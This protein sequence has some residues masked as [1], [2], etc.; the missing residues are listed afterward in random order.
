MIILKN[1]YP[2]Q[3]FDVYDYGYLHGHS[4]LPLVMYLQNGNLT[5][6]SG[7]RI[8]F[9]DELE[10][11]KANLKYYPVIS[12]EDVGIQL[13]DLNSS[14]SSQLRL[15]NWAPVNPSYIYDSVENWYKK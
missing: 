7:H 6:D 9:I 8:G 15:S 11:S 3:K 14:T 12:G 2:G 1:T 5:S 10:K 4:S 13:V